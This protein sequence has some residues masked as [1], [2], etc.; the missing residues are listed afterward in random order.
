MTEDLNRRDFLKLL[1]TLPIL[2]LSGSLTVRDARQEENLPNVLILVFDALSASNISLYGY[3]RTTT[4]NFSRFAEISTVFNRHYAGGS[5]TSPATASILTGTY[6][7]TNRAFHLYGTALDV[8]RYQNI[9]HIIPGDKYTRMTF[10]HND[11]ASMLLYQ[12]GSDIDIHTKTKELCLFNEYILAESVLEN[13]HNAAFLGERTITRGQ[14]G[15]DLQLPSS[16]FLSAV[17]RIWR[18]KGK[19]DQLSD[20][21]DLFPRGLPSTNAGPFVYL[22]EDAI[23]WVQTAISSQSKPYFGYFHFLPPHEPYNTRK[24]FFN[25][26]KDGWAPIAKPQHFFSEGHS[27]D[28][29]N[30]R[31]REY[32][33]YIAY[34]DSEFGRLIEFMTLH[35]MLDDTYIILTSDHGEMFERGILEH[36]T[37]TLFE[38]ITHIPLLV[39]SPGQSIRQDVDSITSSVDLLPTVSHFIGG[40]SPDWCE[41]GILPTFSNIEIDR[42]RSV[43]TIDAK[44]NP[45]NA[46][47]RKCTISMVKGRY[48]IIHYLGYEDFRDEFEIFDLINDPEELENIHPSGGPLVDDLKDELLMNLEEANRSYQMKE[49]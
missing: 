12:F 26:F 21:K 40:V 35:G 18:N 4:P 11:L 13:D 8:F 46:P 43:F 10:T 48:K 47:L 5:F 45:K 41:G 39:H 6:P 36:I 7:W 37:P 38:P 15:Q 28:A 1:G 16:L 25:V 14:R 27:S 42:E 34:V 49:S 20:F 3:P 44:S 30:V 31:R 29:L 9:F 2:T 19:Q 32:D 22:L 33:E 24:D 17:H 23:D